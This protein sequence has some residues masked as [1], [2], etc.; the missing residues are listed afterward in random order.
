MYMYVCFVTLFLLV[1]F[2]SP[3]YLLSSI[4]LSFSS[5]LLSLSSYFS[6]YSSIY[7]ILHLSILSF[8]Y[9]SYPSSIY[10]I[11]HLSIL[12]FI[13]PSSI[14]P[15]FHLSIEMVR[16]RET[17]EKAV[18][19]YV[20]YVYTNT[21]MGNHVDIYTSNSADFNFILASVLVNVM[22]T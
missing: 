19:R 14:Y 22:C 9:L 8:I 15:I 21:I 13:Y 3:S 17:I 12:S 18:Q 16:F 6:H 7:S 1:F 11:L 4:S 2:L 5:Y 10:S 20:Q